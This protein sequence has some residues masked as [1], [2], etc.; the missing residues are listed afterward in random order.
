MTLPIS[1]GD[2]GNFEFRK[3]KGAISLSRSERAP[4]FPL[5]RSGVARYPPDMH[6]RFIKTIATVFFALLVL[7]L[8]TFASISA[9]SWYS[10]WQA[11]R[12]LACLNRFHPGATTEAQ[13]REALKPFSKYETRYEQPEQDK[14]IEVAQY[15]IYNSPRWAGKLS[16]HL[17]DSWERHRLFL[18]WTLFAVSVRYRDGTLAD[19]DIHE[20]QQEN[21]GDPHPYAA[22]VLILATR[23]EKENGRVPDDFTGYSAFT[24]HSQQFDRDNKPVE[25]ER[26]GREYITLD[27]RAS[28]EQ[29]SLSLNFQL[30]CLTSIHPC[31]EIRK[32]RPSVSSLK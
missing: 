5:A 29:R 8:L 10:R 22:S 16:A 26:F 20:M 7:F 14:P 23:F 32:I 30:H 11:S 21:P 28:Q 17:P 2:F 4:D 13:A 3:A 9:T 12:L 15:D 19:L 6:S 24:V 25:P 1:G 31:N 27:E 18:P